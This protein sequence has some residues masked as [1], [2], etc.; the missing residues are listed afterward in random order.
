MQSRAETDRTK[1]PEAD[2]VSNEHTNVHKRLP[3]V[4]RNDWQANECQH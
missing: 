4:K 3:R 1:D 2:P